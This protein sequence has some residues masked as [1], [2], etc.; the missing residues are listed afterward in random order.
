MNFHDSKE[1]V[2]I[3]IGKEVI[4]LGILF[5]GWELK[6]EMLKYPGILTSLGHRI[7]NTQTFMAFSG[8]MTPYAVLGLT[9]GTKKHK[10]NFL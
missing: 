6:V 3:E 8:N 5:D 4:N 1:R 9:L 2:F 7:Q 10:I